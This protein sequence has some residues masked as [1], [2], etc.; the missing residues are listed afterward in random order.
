MVGW[1]YKIVERGGRTIRDLL[2]KSNIF[3]GEKCGREDRVPC[4][5]GEKPQ[6]CRR[7]GLLYE[8]HC[9]ECIE[10]EVK[11]AKYVGESARSAKE[12]FGEHWEDALKKKPDS[13]I[14][15]HWESKH[16]GRQTN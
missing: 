2:T 7:R 8:T 4:E 15:K 9:T 5:M 10:D 1:S 16:D 13:H 11:L 12:R 6:N 3:E 14:F